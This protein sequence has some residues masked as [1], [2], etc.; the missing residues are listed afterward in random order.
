MLKNSYGKI[1]KEKS[2]KTISE[3]ARETS[4]N[5]F[6]HSFKS[7]NSNISESINTYLQYDFAVDTKFLHK[8]LRLSNVLVFFQMEVEY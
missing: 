5:I 7:K 3:N 4:Y 1:D 2:S 8:N 6:T